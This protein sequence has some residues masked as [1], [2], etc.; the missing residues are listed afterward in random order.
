MEIVLNKLLR[1]VLT[2]TT[3]FNATIEE[4][5]NVIIRWD[6]PGGHYHAY[7][8][9]HVKFDPVKRRKRVYLPYLVDCPLIAY[10]WGLYV[11]AGARQAR[12]G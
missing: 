12:L 2:E 7:L 9:K 10:R 3:D 5:Q 1:L 6:G 11:P 4:A 8:L